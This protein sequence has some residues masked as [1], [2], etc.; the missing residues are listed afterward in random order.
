[1]TEWLDA[2]ATDAPDVVAAYRGIEVGRF[3]SV[4]REV[5]RG[6][7]L[8]SAENV[9]AQLDA[10]KDALAAIVRDL[11]DRAFAMPGGEGAWNVAQAVGHV[12]HARAGLSLAAALAASGRFPADAG[13]VVPGVPGSP[14]ATRERLLGRLAT[15]QR[16]IERAARTIAGHETDPCPLDHPLV[17]R[18]RCGEWLLF[19]GVH[20]CMHLEQLHRLAREIAAEIAGAGSTP[21]PTGSTV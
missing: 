20:D 15:S 12:A 10:T 8:G 18:L 7:G 17:G 1:V 9:L 13:P 14:V 19:A 6:A 11:P 4:R 2:L 16:T 21:E 3:I 5:R